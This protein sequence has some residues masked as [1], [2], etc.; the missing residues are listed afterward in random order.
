MR[1]YMYMYVFVYTV[2]PVFKDHPWEESN[3]VF[4]YSWSL[5]AV[6]FMQ[7][8]RNL[9]IKSVVTIDRELLYKPGGRFIKGPKTGLS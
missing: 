7:K 1:T 8:M 6:S 5:I 3:I 4:D 2:K 9:E